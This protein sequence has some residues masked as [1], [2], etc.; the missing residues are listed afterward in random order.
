MTCSIRWSIGAFVLLS[1]F[2]PI[3]AATVITGD[4]SS[5]T[6]T[7]SFAVGPTWFV[8]GSGGSVTTMLVGAQQAITGNT[9]ALSLYSADADQFVPLGVSTITL[10]NVEAQANPLKAQAIKFVRAHVVEDTHICYF[11]VAK[12]TTQ[13]TE[14]FYAIPHVALEDKNKPTEVTISMVQ[15]VVP[16]DAGGSEAAGSIEQLASLKIGDKKLKNV[17]LGAVA[18]SGKNFG[19]G[20]SGIAA[21]QYSSATLKGKTIYS[22]IPWNLASGSAA[23]QA[24]LFNTSISAIKVGSGTPTLEID[25]DPVVDMHWDARLA[26]LYVALRVTAASGANNGARAIVVGRFNE[27]V[28]VF[29]KLVPDAAVVGS[30]DDVIIGAHNGRSASIFKVRTMHTSTGLDYLIVNGGNNEAGSSGIAGVANQVYALPLVHIASQEDEQWRTN[31]KHG[32]LADVTVDPTTSFDRVSQRFVRRLFTK[33]AK[34]AS[35][36]YTTDDQAAVVGGGV[37]PFIPSSAPVRTIGDM[38]VAGDA[39]YVSVPY[40]YDSNG[41]DAIQ[42]PGLYQSQAIFDQRGC[43]IAWTAWQRVAGTDAFIYAARLDARHGNFWY[44]TGTDSSH[45]DTVKQTQWGR[46][47]NDGLLGGTTANSSVGLVNVL[48]EELPSRVG[49]IQGFAQFDAFNSGVVGLTDLL[50][51]GTNKVVFVK[52]GDASAATG[53]IKPYTGNFAAGKAVSTNGTFPTGTGR[54]F[55]CS[56]GD[57]VSLGPLTATTI[58]TW[59]CGC[60]QQCSWIAVGGVHGLAILSDAQG[61]GFAPTTLP[62]GFTFRTVGNYLNVCKIIGD[63]TFLYVLTPHTLDRIELNRASFVSGNLQKTVLATPQ[64]LGF[65]AAGSFSD[66]VIADKLALLATS[67]GL[68][69]ISNGCSVK[70]GTPRW[71]AVPLGES[72][73]P[74]YSL[75]SAESSFGL[76]VG[77]QV[78][79]LG[80]YSGYDEARLYRL[81]VREGSAISSTSVRTIGDM[82]LKDEPSFFVSF[83]QLRSFYFDDGS[84]RLVTRPVN[85]TRVMALYALPNSLRIPVD[86]TTDTQFLAS[87]STLISA[88]ISDYGIFGRPWRLSPSGAWLLYGDFGLRVNE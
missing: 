1:A 84:V 76:A 48:A 49:G 62:Y 2:M 44:L 78:Y 31:A 86:T 39:V 18:E 63:G 16:H 73:G 10:D 52:T 13:Q 64:S 60:A 9:F 27:G 34:T 81:Y 74:V 21:M 46:D 45:T 5:S 54:V 35:Q 20:N 70:I 50:A 17:V 53:T 61:N 65:G 87:H 51:V 42:Q 19:I 82:Y 30:N 83:G 79:A 37:I 57:L 32:T 24:I 69:R 77:G 26:R 72:L 71:T 4:S 56:G 88:E 85:E 36:L 23:N 33:Q 14:R 40:D 59:N 6:K 67:H 15:S 58:F 29:D 25:S 41:N 47:N 28:L 68:Y 12:K 8:S 66:L 43:I 38:F 80:A 22:L 75:S 3:H 7:F 55:S 11:A